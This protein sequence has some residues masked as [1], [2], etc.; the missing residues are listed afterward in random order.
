[1]I[2]EE[3]I[4]AE[5]LRA[6]QEEEDKQK[7]KAEADQDGAAAEDDAKSA[8]KSQNRSQVAVSQKS[9]RGDNST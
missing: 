4:E 8:G 7:K 9:V 3:E 2:I 5:K 6:A 1:M